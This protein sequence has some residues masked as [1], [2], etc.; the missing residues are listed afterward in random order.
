MR[1]A[2]RTDIPHAS[3][4]CSRV[5]CFSI[6][7]GGVGGLVAFAVFIGGSI[8]ASPLNDGASCG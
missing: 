7:F 1:L 3:A 6:A 8:R 2:L 4:I 5:K